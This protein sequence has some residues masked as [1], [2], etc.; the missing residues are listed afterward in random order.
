M[1]R[2]VSGCDTMKLR[3]CL[4]RKN[5]PLVVPKQKYIANKSEFGEIFKIKLGNILIHRKLAQY[6]YTIL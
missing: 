4:N 6:V 1:C 3:Y 2:T 5:K